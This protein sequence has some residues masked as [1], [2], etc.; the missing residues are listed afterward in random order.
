MKHHN[1]LKTALLQFGSVIILLSIIVFCVVL[2]DYKMVIPTRLDTT[3][4]SGIIES[5]DIN[6]NKHYYV[7]KLIDDSTEYRI[8][9]RILTN[10]LRNNNIEK[11]NEI[12]KESDSIKIL[13]INRRIVV[14]LTLN[15]DTILSFEDY[16]QTLIHDHKDNIPERLGISVG[17]LIVGITLVS[18]GLYLKYK[19][20]N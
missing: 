11:L 3:E 19:K 12:I 8:V 14:Q 2:K 9:D 17:L 5:I 1:G 7:L 18:I 15:N 10:G 4:I 13:I 20:N 16:Q 6:K